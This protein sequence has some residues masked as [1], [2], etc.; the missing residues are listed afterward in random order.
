MRVALLYNPRA[1]RSRGERLAREF[2]GLIRAAGHEARD[3][4]VRS[5]APV[6]EELVSWCEVVVVAGGD[7]T[8]HRLLP[9][10]VGSGRAVYHAALGTEN[11]FAREFGHVA[12]PAAVVAAIAAGRSRAV[13]VGEIVVAGERRLFAIMASV[14]PDAGVVHRMDASRRGAITRGS[15]LAPILAE[16]RAPSLPRM[17]VRVDG[18]EVVRDRRGMVVVANLC[19]YALGLNPAPAAR[20]D[21]AMLD[22]VFLPASSAWRVMANLA[23]CR[24][25]VAERLG[26]V[27]ARGEKVEC[28]VDAGSPVQ[29]DGEAVRLDSHTKTDRLDISAAIAPGKLRVLRSACANMI[30]L[31]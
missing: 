22:V 2:V 20:D 31:G 6:T 24:L 11:L 30:V 13:D 29:I 5:N 21:D 10:V 12:D 23:A 27:R 17:A 9:L 18:R 1:G 7:G 4:D 19:R 16:L 25:G 28:F 3:A 15:Y 8:L 14:G 26:A